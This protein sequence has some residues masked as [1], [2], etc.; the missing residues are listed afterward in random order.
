MEVSAW[1]R[2]AA[3]LDGRYMPVEQAAIP[4]L[5]WGYRRS[6]A[7]YDV[8]GVWKG[9]FFRL[10]DHIKRFRSSMRALRLDPPESDD[11]I[12]FILAECVRRSGLREAYVAMDCLR[13]TPMAGQPRHPWACRNYLAA[14][15]IPWVWVIEPDVQERG[16]HLIVAKTRRISEASVDSR[17]KNFHWGDMTR[18]LFEAHDQGAQTCILL[19]KDGLVTEGPGFNVFIV[20]ERAV[21]TPDRGV[22]EGITRL[23]VAELCDELRLP[24]ELRPV[25]AAELH[26]ADEIFLSTTA[27]GI[28]PVSRLDG[29]ILGHDRPG[30]ISSRLRETFWSKRAAGWHAT[31]IDYEL[32]APAT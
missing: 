32:N 13:G 21:A 24:F 12:R 8:V 6:D 11:E 4:V 27:G 15:A 17:V 23:S 30:P 31:P 20:R 28:M 26:D 5:D 18:G 10:D 3:Y 7:T 14:F 1:S 25:A 16:A 9:N 2:G 22:L 29:R 19:D